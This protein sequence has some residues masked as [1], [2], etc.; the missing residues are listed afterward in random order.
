MSKDIFEALW[1][2]ETEYLISDEQL[3]FLEKLEDLKTLIFATN[4]IFN[5]VS[6]SHTDLKT[7]HIV[8][9]Y[10]AIWEQV[11]GKRTTYCHLVSHL[12]SVVASG[13]Q[14]KTLTTESIEICQ[15]LIKHQISHN[16]HNSIGKA[17]QLM[18]IA[19]IREQPLIIKK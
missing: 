4:H 17:A 11:I 15:K 3:F 18:K 5:A 8:S 13:V 6:N 9:Q 10:E 14:V 2:G 19:N 7:W 16:T 1:L 12:A